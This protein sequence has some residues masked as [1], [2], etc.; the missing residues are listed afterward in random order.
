MHY[1]WHDVTSTRSSISPTMDYW[2]SI[3]PGGPRAARFALRD[4]PMLCPF[5]APASAVGPETDVLT[6]SEVSSNLLDFSS[7]LAA[8][9]AFLISARDG[10]A[11]TATGTVLALTTVPTG[12]V[13]L[14]VGTPLAPG[15]DRCSRMPLTAEWG[16]MKS[17]L[18]LLP[19]PL[20]WPL[21][22]DRSAEPCSTPS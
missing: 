13:L 3:G 11:G 8:A 20:D 6:F 14:P 1:W 9:A 5:G 10:V 2:N 15:A 12:L 22:S 18:N 16:P 21:K 19:W 7:S 4:R 17:F